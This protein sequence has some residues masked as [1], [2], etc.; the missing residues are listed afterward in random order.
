MISFVYCARAAAAVAL[1]AFSPKNHRT[2]P[3]TPNDSASVSA[4]A[5]LRRVLTRKASSI[6]RLSVATVRCCSVGIRDGGAERDSGGGCDGDGGGG[7]GL[8][9]SGAYGGGGSSVGA[10]GEPLLLDGM[11]APL[12]MQAVSSWEWVLAAIEARAPTLALRKE[13][14]AAG[15]GSRVVDYLRERMARKAK[16]AE[17]RRIMRS[18]EGFAAERRDDALPPVGRGRGEGPKVQRLSS[19]PTA[20][21]RRLGQ[22]DGFAEATREWRSGAGESSGVYNSEMVVDSA[23][24]GIMRNHSIPARW[25]IPAALRPP[26]PASLRWKPAE[27]DAGEEGAVSLSVAAASPFDEYDSYGVERTHAAPERNAAHWARSAGRRP[28]SPAAGRRS[29]GLE[30]KARGGRKQPRI[31]AAQR[32]QR[33]EEEARR[34]RLRHATLQAAA[35]HRARG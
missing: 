27:G 5:R 35:R 17:T 6:D 22:G 28:S 19:R 15:N 13:R 1:D 25:Q 23:R 11:Q 34:A 21:P 16:E 31:N 26:R 33:G 32:R 3:P 30:M 7:G 12:G 18:A 14:G 24:T 2:Q 9:G 8:G 10:A 20:G 4:R 29:A